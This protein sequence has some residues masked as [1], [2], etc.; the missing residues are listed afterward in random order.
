MKTPGIH[1]LD[2]MAFARL[3]VLKTTFSPLEISAAT[4]ASGIDESSITTSPKY[5]STN[6]PISLFESKPSLEK[7]KFFAFS[8]RKLRAMLRISSGCIP[9]A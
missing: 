9:K 8:Q 7:V 6:L 1:V 3:P 4:M 5:F 2:M